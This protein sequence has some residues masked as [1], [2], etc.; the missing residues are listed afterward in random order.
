[1]S[2]LYI[3]H[4]TFH[5][6]TCFLEASTLGDRHCGNLSV[7]NALPVW[8]RVDDGKD[9]KRLVV[10]L[11]PGDLSSCITKMTLHSYREV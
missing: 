3:S 11:R 7:D 4:S 10:W 8:K 5:D 6:D 1:M 9:I 2:R